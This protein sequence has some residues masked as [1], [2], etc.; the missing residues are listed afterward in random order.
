MPTE[1]TQKY[2]QCNAC[3]KR[4]DTLNEA[5][6]CEDR[7]YFLN[8]KALSVGDEV[9]FLKKTRNV[10]S[11]ADIAALT[12]RG[13]VLAIRTIKILSHQVYQYRVKIGEKGFETWVE[14]WYTSKHPEA[15]LITAPTYRNQ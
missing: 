1:I 12:L 4:Y 10:M 3:L 6:R 11:P 8:G 5:T 14:V 2:Y 13:R 15:L 9:D 7:R